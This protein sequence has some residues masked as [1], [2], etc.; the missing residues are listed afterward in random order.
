MDLVFQ[1]VQPILA[2][3]A[4][5]AL[6][7][8]CSRAMGRRWGQ[9]NSGRR[10]RVLEQ[11]PCGRDMRLLLVEWEGRQLLIGAG[12]SGMTL[13]AEG[14][15]GPPSHE[16]QD[17]AFAGEEAAAFQKESIRRLVERFAAKKD[18]KGGSGHG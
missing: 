12:P 14:E 7:Y 13:L 8:W 15:A 1:L 10:L 18:K 2:V 5:L 6:A 4:V 9:P 11:V 17:G 16:E 3:A